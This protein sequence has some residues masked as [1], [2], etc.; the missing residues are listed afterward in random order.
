MKRIL[1]FWLSLAMLCSIFAV[2]VKAETNTN[3]NA[4]S[5]MITGEAGEKVTFRYDTSTAVMTFSGTGKLVWRPLRNYDD[6]KKV[7][8]E[9]GITHLELILGEY[10]HGLEELTIPESVQEINVT[11]A[12]VL[13]DNYKLRKIINKSPVAFDPRYPAD[14]SLKTGWNRKS[15]NNVSKEIKENGYSPLKWLVDGKE[16]VK[17]PARSEAAAVPRTYKI[18]YDLKG[19]KKTKGSWIKSYMYGASR[20]L[21][22]PKK[23]GYLF[24]GWEPKTQVK[25]HLYYRLYSKVSPVQYSDVKLTA[26]WRKVKVVK[27]KKNS[28]IQ[29]QVYPKNNP[30]LTILVSTK[31]DIARALKNKTPDKFSSVN[32]YTTNSRTNKLK[33]G[34]IRN[35]M[36]IYNINRFALFKPESPGSVKKQ[37]FKKG[38]TYYVWIKCGRMQPYEYGEF[39]DEDPVRFVTD[40]AYYFYKTKVKF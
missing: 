27:D 7:V 40:D 13:Q 30:N 5:G 19:G 26:V 4:D 14:H 2:P 18:T 33:K 22:K 10:F 29:I 3:A 17:I 34:R 21:P 23:K 9:E 20:K 6:V 8:I 37:K 11:G 24:A 31:K 15:D 12:K 28:S 16:V 38:K 39:E 36:R 35:G 32:M 25:S 1:S